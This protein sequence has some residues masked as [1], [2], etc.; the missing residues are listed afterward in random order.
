[1][2]MNTPN[3]ERC[4]DSLKGE[5]AFIDFGHEGIYLANLSPIEHNQTSMHIS[6]KGVAAFSGD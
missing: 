6:R 5:R 4:I 1:M 2:W 3:G